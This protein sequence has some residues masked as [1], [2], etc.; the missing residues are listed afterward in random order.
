MWDHDIDIGMYLDVYVCVDCVV[1]SRYLH[2]RDPSGEPSSDDSGTV[3]IQPR[4]I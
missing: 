4:G 3:S 1:P 2:S